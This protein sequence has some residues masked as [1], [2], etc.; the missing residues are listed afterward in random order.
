MK[1][2]NSFFQVL[3]LGVGT[4]LMITSVSLL[5]TNQVEFILFRFSG[6]STLELSYFDTVLYVAYLTMAIIT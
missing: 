6:L 1:N 2:N 4:M 3:F 5:H